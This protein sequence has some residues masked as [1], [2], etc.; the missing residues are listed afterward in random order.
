MDLLLD[1]THM[2]RRRPYSYEEEET[3]DLLL[4]HTEATYAKFS[5]LFL[6]MYEEEKED[7]CRV[8]YD[9]SVVA[10]DLEKLSLMFVYEWKN[11]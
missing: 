1:L 6:L 10:Y 3:C 2:R 5:V 8:G 4:D 7:A 9:T 11:T